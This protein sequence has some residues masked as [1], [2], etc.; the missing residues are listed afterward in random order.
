MRLWLATFL[1]MATALCLR[2]QQEEQKKAVP[3]PLTQPN[4]VQ[5]GTIEPLKAHE[6]VNLALGNTFGAKA[7][8]NRAM[9]AGI[10]QW[11]DK[12]EEWP[13]GGK[14]YGMRYTS[15]WGRLAVRQFVQT[16]AD[17]AFKT[18]PRYDRCSC[19]GFAARA[20][21]AWRRVLIAR[22][23]NGGETIGI[24]RLAAAYVVPTI[25]DQWEPDRVNTVSGKLTSG[26]TFFGWRGV[27]NMIKEFWPE[28]RRTVLR[29]DN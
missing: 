15:R 24:S 21:H 14:G 5:P 2:A 22:K 18:D 20:G 26:T 28:I 29:R 11:R 4:V 27:T 12:P 13:S 7:L 9:L 3:L 1:W 19:T 16:S 25:T 8:L 6:K 10:D 23:D 17:V